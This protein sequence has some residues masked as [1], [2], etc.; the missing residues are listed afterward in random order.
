MRFSRV[1]VL[2]SAGAVFFLVDAT[3]EL[4][5]VELN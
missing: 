5:R 3:F 4:I 1:L 2:M